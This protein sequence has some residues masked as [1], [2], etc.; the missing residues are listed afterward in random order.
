MD[1]AVSKSLLIMDAA[2]AIPSS[3]S[4]LRCPLHKA[5]IAFIRNGTLFTTVLAIAI[6]AG[7][8]SLYKLCFKTCIINFSWYSLLSSLP[9]SSGTSEVTASSSGLYAKSAFIRRSL[10]SVDAFLKYTI[11]L[12][13]LSSTDTS[14]TPGRLAM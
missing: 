5:F 13:V 9:V 14:L 1:D 4:T 8:K 12:P 10:S 7:R 11:A 6:G 2:I 3:V